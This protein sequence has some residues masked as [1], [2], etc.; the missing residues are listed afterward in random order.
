MAEDWA[1]RSYPLA[2]RA[3]AH[4][5]RRRGWFG[6]QIPGVLRSLMEVVRVLFVTSD[7]HMVCY[8]GKIR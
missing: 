4:L 1:V 7:V 2:C 3:R 8:Q 5:S 6:D